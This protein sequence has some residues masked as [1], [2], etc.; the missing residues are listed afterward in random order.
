MTYFLYL[1]DFSCYTA[2]I[3]VDY[4]NDHYTSVT[5]LVYTAK[6]NVDYHNDHYTRTLHRTLNIEQHKP[7]RQ[8]TM[9]YRT[10]H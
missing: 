7:H 10:E 3:N 2:K 8:Q 9:I 5:F 6:T 1:S 4:H